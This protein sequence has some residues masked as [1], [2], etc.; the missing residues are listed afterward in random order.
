MFSLKT[1]KTYQS[2][3]TKVYEVDLERLVCT[4]AFKA[5]NV[6]ELHNINADRGKDGPGS[7]TYLEF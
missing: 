7:E 5:V 1:R 4:S 2:P 6:D 3:H